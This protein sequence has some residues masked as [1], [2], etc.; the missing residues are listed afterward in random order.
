MK[1]IIVKENEE[2][3]LPVVWLGKEKEINY[4]IQLTGLSSSLIFLMLLLGGKKDRVKIKIGV[5][6]QNKETKS[7][8]IVKGIVENNANVDFEGKV[9]IEPGSKGSNAWLSANLLLLSDKAKGRA[10]PALEI[11]ENDIKAGHA[12]TVGKVSDAELFYL[13]SR[14]LSRI[15]ARDLI[16]QGFLS[17]FLQTFPNGKIKEEARRRLKYEE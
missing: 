14:G 16:I 1:N 2:L 12:T 10:V 8:V 5:D 9:R 13:M 3:I 15:K 11:L 6:H 17:G 7:K 4:N